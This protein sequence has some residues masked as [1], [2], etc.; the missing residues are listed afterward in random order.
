[1]AVV[2][3]ILCEAE[4]QLVASV[5]LG[6][7]MLSTGRDTLLFE[8]RCLKTQWGNSLNVDDLNTAL[9]HQRGKVCREDQSQFCC[10]VSHVHAD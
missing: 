3:G 9:P 5:G 2:K 4:K 8:G 1:M 7:I 10:Q 6:C